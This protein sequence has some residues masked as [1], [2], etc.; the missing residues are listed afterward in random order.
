MKNA[1]S[2]KR[3]KGYSLNSVGNAQKIGTIK[4]AK[5]KLTDKLNFSN[6]LLRFYKNTGFG[7]FSGNIDINGTPTSMK[8]KLYFAG[9]KN[10]V[11]ETESLAYNGYFEFTHIPDDAI[12]DMYVVD[13]TTKY[14]TKVKENIKCEPN[15]Y[16]K[17]E[18]DIVGISK[19]PPHESREIRF[20]LIAHN[21]VKKPKY[22]LKNK[23][24]WLSVD[25]NTGAC[26][27]KTSEYIR[28]LGITCIVKDGDK[29][30]EFIRTV[31]FDDTKLEV[32]FNNTIDDIHGAFDVSLLSE[33]NP[34]FVDFPQGGKAI[35]IGDDCLVYKPK[36]ENFYQ[37]YNG[38]LSIEL[39][40]KIN[41]LPTTNGLIL[42]TDAWNK[43]F[44]QIGY[45]NGFYYVDLCDEYNSAKR[46]HS[47]IPVE[48][49][50][51]CV[52]SLF[53]NTAS[54]F[55]IMYNGIKLDTVSQSTNL[56]FGE[57]FYIGNNPNKN[58]YNSDLTFKKIT[59]IKNYDMY[60]NTYVTEYPFIDTSLLLKRYDLIYLP[61]EQRDSSYKPATM[62]AKPFQNNG[63]FFCN[64][65][66][67]TAQQYVDLPNTTDVINIGSS[68]WTIQFD[69]LLYGAFILN[70]YSSYDMYMF[71]TYLNSS[72]WSYLGFYLT[73]GN[74]YRKLQPIIH[75]GQGSYTTNFDSSTN[76]SKID[77]LQRHFIK[78]VRDK[79]T[80]YMFNNGKLINKVSIAHNKE[81]E[82]LGKNNP[83]RMGVNS[84]WTSSYYQ[85]SQYSTSGVIFEP[86]VADT[87]EYDIFEKDVSKYY[88]IKMV[89]GNIIKD[90]YYD[91]KMTVNGNITT[92]N[93]FLHNT[94]THNIKLDDEF[95]FNNVLTI[96]LTGQTVSNSQ[97]QNLLSLKNSS[98]E[99]I[100]VTA[101]ASGINFEINTTS[102]VNTI[103]TN[104]VKAQNEV[105]D[106]VL[107]SNGSTLT[108][109]ID[110][111]ILT[112]YDITLADF[113][114]NQCYLGT[115]KDGVIDNEASSTIT[116]FQL[117][118]DIYFVDTL[119]VL[120]D[121]EYLNKTTYKFLI[122][123]YTYNSTTAKNLYTGTALSKKSYSHWIQ[124][125]SYSTCKPI[126]DW[127]VEMYVTFTSNY[128]SGNQWFYESYGDGD[129]SYS[130]FLIFMPVN[131]TLNVTFT[132]HADQVSANRIS[133]SYTTPETFANGES[134]HLAVC[135]TGDFIKIFINGILRH[136]RLVKGF[137]P[138]FDCD[139]EA[140]RSN[141]RSAL[142]YN[143]DAHWVRGTYQ[144][145]RILNGIALYENN[146]DVSR[147]TA[148]IPSEALT[149]FPST[150]ALPLR[151]KMKK[152]N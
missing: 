71:S 2:L 9:T 12:Y 126:G 56:M 107:T 52:F 134:V 113:K 38:R 29:E 47:L 32:D 87:N 22:I 49:D 81:F 142:G 133:Y 17:I 63:S 110:G 104:I 39:V 42:S 124:D 44:F 118:R 28:S 5:L 16:K 105:Y 51:W 146:F 40:F 94:N 70:T 120:H 88:D 4:G 100:Q 20:T 114:F 122:Q 55:T 36:S 35:H 74:Y 54:E 34:N 13:P 75:L 143:S 73:T 147:V 116:Y 139:N 25:E 30:Y 60:S 27:G 119:S 19:A 98:G 14:D 101:N 92:N 26:S 21:T 78:V 62:T 111:E 72:R 24:A 68:N 41:S 131:R 80:I 115:N 91:N 121:V 48:V 66:D 151:F 103:N 86:N 69:V 33:N 97:V 95:D 7:H 127:T 85:Y 64:S 137:I 129:G 152:V 128:T 144:Y 8:V 57:N 109:Q 67:S 46:K 123:N 45:E 138:F 99:Y 145:F 18:F 148:S 31:L 141:R 102:L 84:Y 53:R 6:L 37:I 58:T 61:P 125:M 15:K 117:S 1:I 149:Q 135:R 96:R 10:L 65:Y 90:P 50:K 83:L 82:F 43:T 3:N 76:T 79:N 93:Y 112:T 132:T 130:N 150:T 59:L 11:K 106:I 108:V 140:H 136:T 23:P 77:I 89:S